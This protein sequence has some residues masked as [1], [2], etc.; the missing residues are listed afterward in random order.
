MSRNASKYTGSLMTDSAKCGTLRKLFPIPQ[1][2]DLCYGFRQDY[3][4]SRASF[5]ALAL[6]TVSP[7]DASAYLQQESELQDIDGDVIKWTRS[8]FQIPP[9]WDDWENVSYTFP[10]YPGYLILPIGITTPV[11][12]GNF[13]PIN[14]VTCR[15]H[16]DYFMVG[17]GRTYANEGAIPEIPVQ[18]FVGLLN[19][20]F[21]I[22]PPM[23]V[24]PGTITVGSSSYLESVP[25]QTTWAGWVANAAANK[26]SSGT[27]QA[28][29]SGQGQ[30]VIS[31]KP[32]RLVGNSGVRG[33]T[34]PTI[35]GVLYR[36]CFA[37][38]HSH[39]IFPRLLSARK[40]R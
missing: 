15:V 40:R 21:T 33:A 8:Y 31:C 20:T 4:Q 16:R 18:A 25:N 26:W 3:M 38:A 30:I 11:G 22:E 24:G 32:E 13:T 34:R 9:S 12:R 19:P 10:A 28:V 37:G 27:A 1:I 2:G 6:N 14:G 39:K 35:A 36:G 29:G 7:D 17:A 5:A 23:V